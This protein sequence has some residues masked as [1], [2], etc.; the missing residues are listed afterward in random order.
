M[1]KFDGNLAVKSPNVYI[2]YKALRG[3][4]LDAERFSNINKDPEPSSKVKYS[5]QPEWKLISNRTIDFRNTVYNRNIYDP[6]TKVSNRNTDIG[7][8][9]MV[10]KIGRGE[11][12]T[13][14]LYFAQAGAG[15]H[16]DQLE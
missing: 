16:I 10:K 15:C 5:H 12:A 3:L 1:T 7:H 6:K 4:S 2:G 8:N 13:G 9:L 11:Q 14:D